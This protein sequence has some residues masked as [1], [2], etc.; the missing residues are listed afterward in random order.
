M[1]ALSDRSAS[2]R[3]VTRH[4]KLTSEQFNAGIQWFRRYGGVILGRTITRND[5][6]NRYI[7]SETVG[8]SNDADSILGYDVHL[9]KGIASR[10]MTALAVS[11]TA[12]SSA[13]INGDTLA[14]ATLK[15]RVR[16]FWDVLESY[17]DEA[18]S[19]G[20]Q[21]EKDR[22]ENFLLTLKRP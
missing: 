4:L 12:H 11:V 16:G 18:D 6:T 20:Y 7:L 22:I 8:D 13:E 9:N 3:E 21:V 19:L 15:R 1:E 2:K 5:S 17:A 10:S 14:A